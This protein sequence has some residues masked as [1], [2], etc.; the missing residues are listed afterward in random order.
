MVKNILACL[1]ASLFTLVALAA[2]AQAQ[3][4]GSFGS[5]STGSLS[6]SASV[7]SKVRI[8]GLE[9]VTF[10]SVDPSTNASSAQNVC[11]FSNTAS[12]GYNITATG[13]GTAG[14]FTLANGALSPVSYSV[15]F[16]DTADQTS[17]SALT[18]GSSLTGLTSSAANQNCTGGE[19]ASLIVGIA[20]SEL[21]KMQAGLSYAGTL[22]LVVAP[23]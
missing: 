9:N 10:A 21:Q 3:T 18:S 2:P 12:G 23:E 5:T 13:D 22:T 16:A 11:V 7:P 8:S 14:A 17:G 15:A 4:D 1:L 19:T 6:V 20:S